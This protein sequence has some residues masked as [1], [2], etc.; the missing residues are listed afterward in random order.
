MREF[1][2][3]DKRHSYVRS[4]DMTLSNVRELERKALIYF[5]RFRL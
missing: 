5:L 2:R 1:A 3:K 4:Y